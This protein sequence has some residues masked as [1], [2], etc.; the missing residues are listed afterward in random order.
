MRAIAEEC[1]LSAMPKQIFGKLK[2]EK[3]WKLRLIVLGEEGEAG[4]KRDVTK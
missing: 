4:K 3:S 2:A 1:T